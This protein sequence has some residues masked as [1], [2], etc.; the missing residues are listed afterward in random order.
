MWLEFDEDLVVRN[1]NPA[2]VT[3]SVIIEE[4]LQKLT[5]LPAD[6]TTELPSTDTTTIAPPIPILA[7]ALSQLNDLNRFFQSMSISAFAFPHTSTQLSIQDL[8][9]TLG[10]AQEGLKYYQQKHKILCKRHERHYD[11]TIGWVRGHIGIE[12][13]HKAGQQALLWSLRGRLCALPSHTTP[14]GTIERV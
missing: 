9:D 3:L 13:N 5:S 8:V 10:Q 7:E 11:T 2:V 1:K 6:N 12:G 4:N 14:A